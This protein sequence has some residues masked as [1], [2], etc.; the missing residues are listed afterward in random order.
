MSEKCYL[1][2]DI[3]W[4]LYSRD[5]SVE[6]SGFRGLQEDTGVFHGISGEFRVVHDRFKDFQVMTGTFR[7]KGG[8]QEINRI[9]LGSL[10]GLF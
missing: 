2:R 7:M 4:L 10:R 6:G 5:N 3:S 1:G 8:V 9:A